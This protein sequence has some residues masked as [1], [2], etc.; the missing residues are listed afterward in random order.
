[1]DLVKTLAGEFETREDYVRNILALID[2]GNTIPFIARYR[3]EQTGSMDD[4][5]LRRMDERL[6]YLRG[7][8][9]RKA[10]VSASIEEQGKL[11]D[12]L[13][14]ALLA[15]ETKARIEDIYLP[16]KTKRRTK[17]Q[18][19]REAGLEPLADQLLSD[20]VHVPADAA[21]P[22]VDPG[23][24]VGDTDEALAGARAIVSE[25]F[26]ED[27]DLIGELR[28]RLWTRATGDFGFMELC[29]F[30][31]SDEVTL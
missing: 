15:A 30:S 4:Q 27:A 26:G 8:E 19:A 11:T 23:R 6:T 22:F 16:Y 7:L 9:K 5:L 12:E 25:R 3:K 1:M 20:P 13:R 18:I 31:F 17:A 24:G 29:E 2:E 21:L 28:E 14:A 10:E